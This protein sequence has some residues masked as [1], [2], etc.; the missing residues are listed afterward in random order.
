MPPVHKSIQ[1]WTLIA[2]LLAFIAAN[3]VPNFP[4]S[5]EVIL[6]VVVYVLGLVGIVPELKARRLM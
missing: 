3:Y 1:F 2:G 5:K 6:Q 4:L